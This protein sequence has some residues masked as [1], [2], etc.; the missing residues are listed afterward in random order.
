MAEQ[1]AIC[2]NCP[3]EITRYAI[4]EATN[5]WSSWRHI[6]TGQEACSSTTFASPVGGTIVSETV[7][8]RAA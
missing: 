4:K 1:S 8:D 5:A 2:I 3:I 7:V 6:D